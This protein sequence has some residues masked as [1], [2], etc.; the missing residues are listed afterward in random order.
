MNEGAEV[1]NPYRFVSVLG[2]DG[3]PIEIDALQA[4][5][6]KVCDWGLEA[7]MAELQQDPIK[8]DTTERGRLTAGIVQQRMSGLTRNELPK[9][10]DFKIVVGL[11]IGKYFSHW[12]KVCIHGNA[13]GH[14]IDYG[15]M[16]THGLS[17]TSDEAAI[18]TAVF[19]SLEAWRIDIQ[20]VNKPDFVLIDSGD[21][22]QA[23]Y[24][25][26]RQYGSPFAAAKGHPGGK[27]QMSSGDSPTRLHFEAARADFQTKE[28]IWLYNLDSEYW[29]Q[30]VQQRFLTS[31]LNEANQLNAGSLSVWSTENHKE[32]LSYSHHIVAEERQESFTPGKGLIRKWVVTNRNNHW[33]DAT[34]LALAAGGILG[35]KVIPRQL[36]IPDRPRKVNRFLVQT[37]RPFVP[38]DRMAEL[39]DHTTDLLSNHQSKK[40]S[41]QSR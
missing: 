15:V 36:P 16:E 9:V 8:T 22:T 21:V 10:D 31:T 17:A 25:F 32:H 27:L 6:N 3:Q 14:V 1:G 30:Q 33:L 37:G 41:R 28:G 20:A 2:E 7:V 39:W 18:E 11:D 40:Q 5:F 24:A 29:K 38:Q 26:V 19:K 35:I 13:T 4:F 23:V 12:T 34:A